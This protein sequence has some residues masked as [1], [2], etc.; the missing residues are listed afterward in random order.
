[1]STLVVG[2]KG[3]PPS[4]TVTGAML[5]SADRILVLGDDRAISIVLQRLMAVPASDRPA[6][7]VGGKRSA[8]TRLFAHPIGVESSMARLERGDTYPFDVG[9]VDAAGASTY[10]LGHA[11]AGSTIDP[12][13]TFPWKGVRGRVAIHGGARDT[14]VENAA[15][16]L[17][18]NAQHHGRWTVSPRSA[19]MDGRLEIH[20][21]AGRRPDL[22]RVRPAL[23][24]GNHERS[25]FVTR[26]ILPEARIE[27]PEAWSVAADGL[28]TSGGDL[29]VSVVRAG[30]TLLV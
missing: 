12:G 10:F 21:F 13:W 14:V 22:H 23:R 25:P 9:V 16:L 8:T 26:R 19:A 29:I 4:D 11:A 5:A 1:M 2:G 6:I 18:S 30:I 27:I 20:V 24:A 17:I 3:G 7:A 15:G 28:A